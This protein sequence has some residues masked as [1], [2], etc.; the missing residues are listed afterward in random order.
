MHILRVFCIGRVIGHAS[1]HKRLLLF[2]CPDEH[3]LVICSLESFFNG[4]PCFIKLCV[5]MLSNVYKFGHVILALIHA[6]CSTCHKLNESFACVRV[7][8]VTGINVQVLHS[9]Y[10]RCEWVL[11]L[12]PNSHLSLE[13]V[14]GVLSW[15]SQRGRL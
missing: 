13:S 2:T 1:N 11:P 14:L 12:F 3:L 8:Q 5:Y 4:C 15:N 10:I 6:L 7:F 9:F